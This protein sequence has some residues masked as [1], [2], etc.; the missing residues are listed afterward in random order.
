VDLTG[1][2]AI[3][4]GASRGIGKQT[5]IRL[6]RRGA[7]IVIAART[8][9]TRKSVPGTLG[10]TLAAI[11][12]TGAQARAVQADMADPE[13]LERLVATTLDAFGG[14]DVLINNAAATGSRSWGAPLLDLSRRDWMWQYAVNLHAP[15]TL[16]RAVVPIMRQRG[17]GRII[18]VTTGSPEV[19]RQAGVDVGVNQDAGHTQEAIGT[20]PLAYT[21]SKAALDRFCAVV[22]PQLRPY[23][24]AIMNMHPGEVH[25]E[26]ADVLATRGYDT[27]NMIPM[28]IPAKALTYLASCDDP[29]AYTGR[30]L[31]AEKLVSDLDL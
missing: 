31:V 23:G 2:T 10:D 8:M 1:R 27:S 20:A 21:S 15:F 11:E 25:T 14:V 28:D 17:G 9:E 22:A 30:L 6:G 3:I 19:L 24:I 26:L 18:N 16:A 7:N 12:A 29:M 13:D 4:T 5:A